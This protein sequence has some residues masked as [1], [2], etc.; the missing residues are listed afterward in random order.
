M[1]GVFW[2]HNFRTVPF[3]LIGWRWAAERNIG[4][5]VHGGHGRTW[6]GDRT[7]L[8]YA[9]QYIDGFRHELGMSINGLFDWFRLDFSKR[10][11]APGFFVS[12][13]FVQF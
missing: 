6:F 7:L 9:P 13:G 3:E 2:E 4:L 5:I 10:L 11:D 8:D 1:L 12:V